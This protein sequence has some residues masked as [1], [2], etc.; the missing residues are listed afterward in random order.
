MI[1]LSAAEAYEKKIELPHL[2]V[3]GAGNTIEGPEFGTVQNA[4]T[5]A[6][7]I[8]ANLTPVEVIATG[9]G[10]EDE[11][12]P[13]SEA[14]A[15]RHIILNKT[16]QQGVAAVVHTE[17]SSRTTIQNIEGVAPLVEELGFDAI[18]IVAAKGHADRACQ[19]SRRVM[20][21][22][23]DITP[24][25]SRLDVSKKAALNETAL[26]VLYGALTFGVDTSDASKLAKAHN[27]Y[28]GTV[29]IPKKVVRLLKLSSKY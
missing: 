9:Y 28:S 15:I 3:L 2:L 19:I 4:H 29:K 23:V 18:A 7:L 10:P 16:S 26:S 20:G 25:Y 27:R 24:V 14:E 17:Q 5:A 22:K 1:G 21:K 6:G 11:Y 12:F 8:L 13:R